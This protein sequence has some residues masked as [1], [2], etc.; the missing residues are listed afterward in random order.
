[1]T[2]A[3]EILDTVRFAFIVIGVLAFAISGALLAAECRMDIVGLSG[4][5]IVTATGGGVVR[6][7]LI[8]RIPPAVLV[9]IWMVGVAI[10]AAIAVFFFAR[11]VQR[12]HRAV[13][14][15]DAIGLGLFCVDATWLAYTH[16]L[17][18]VAC[19]AVGTVTGIGGGIMRDVLAND[20]PAVFRRDSR[21]YLIPALAGSG[22]V[23]TLLAF[24]VTG[25]IMLALVALGIVALRILSEVF[26]WRVPA[27]KTEM[28]PR[29]EPGQR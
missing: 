10:L 24:G 19:A 7:V 22:M 13:L 6:D 5:A 4:L 1:M 20:V 21:L 3:A 11:H 14:V 29:I 28:L 2:D 16:G 27:P 9:D 15:F 23:A 26:R 17:H 18:P 12:L 8:G 25:P